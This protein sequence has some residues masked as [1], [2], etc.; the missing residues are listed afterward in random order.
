MTSAEKFYKEHFVVDMDYELDEENMATID[1]MQQYADQ[2]CSAKDTR[3]KE[4]E[5]GLRELRDDVR[6][7]P[8]DA[9]YAT[10]LE[11]ANQLL[12]KTS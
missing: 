9:R 2:E 1:A 6:R 7:K 4:L 10:A 5:D 11:K 12:N 8:N 3:I